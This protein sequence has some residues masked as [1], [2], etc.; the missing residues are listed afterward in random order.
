MQRRITFSIV[1]KNINDEKA[2]QPKQDDL[3]QKL[4]AVIVADLRRAD[5]DHEGMTV[6]RVSVEKEVITGATDSSEAD[7]MG[8]HILDHPQKMAVK[9]AA[10]G[11]EATLPGKS[12]QRL[13]KL[14]GSILKR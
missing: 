11:D 2:V 6:I 8:A 10:I 4:L 1:D 13:V 3:A 9:E 7:H 5:N 12:D 14:G